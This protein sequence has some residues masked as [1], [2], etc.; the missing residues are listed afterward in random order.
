MQSWPS[1]IDKDNKEK[2]D[3]EVAR[4]WFECRTQQEIAEAVG[5]TQG[6][7]AK[8]LFQVETFRFV[9]KLGECREIEDETERMDVRG[10]IVRLQSTPQTSTGR[11]TTP[12]SSRN[13][14]RELG[15]SRGSGHGMAACRR[16]RP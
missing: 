11:F 16:S 13:G 12:G 15:N 1:R 3:A 9:I 4:L 14:R 7:I 8:V 5:M 2:R 6:A 10:F